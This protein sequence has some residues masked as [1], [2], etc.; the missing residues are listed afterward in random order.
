MLEVGSTCEKYLITHVFI[1][2]L[3]CMAFHHVKD[4]CFRVPQRPHMYW[5]LII[6]EH[7][8]RTFFPICNTLHMNVMIIYIR[9]KWLVNKE[10]C[11]WF[12]IEQR[13]RSQMPVAAYS[14]PQLQ[15]H[16][17]GANFLNSVHSNE[18]GNGIFSQS[19]CS[20]IPYAILASD[21][22][23]NPQGIARTRHLLDSPTNSKLHC[24]GCF[25]SR[26]GE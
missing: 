14:S 2:P 13:I 24:D 26:A 10:V 9:P 12:W 7:L 17:W 15:I 23:R 19:P 25:T 6:F 5:V 18:C 11:R 3:K 4:P 8:Y 1:F 20:Q 22:S 21:T 16:E